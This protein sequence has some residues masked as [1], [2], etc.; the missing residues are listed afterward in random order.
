MNTLTEKEMTLLK[1]EK[2]NEETCVEK[3]NQYASQA[4]C[5]Q[6]KALFQELGSKEQEHLNTIN[7]IMSG[8]VPNV[9]ASQ[10][11]GQSSQ[12]QAMTQSQSTLQSQAISNAQPQATS[13]TNKKSDCYLCTDAL[14][15]E[16]HVS[17]TY[18]TAIFEFADTNIRQALNHIQ[19]EEQ[20]HG[21]QIYNYMDQNGMYN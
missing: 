20:E 14:S 9:N 6:L 4:S 16:K 3:Y 18:N 2:K 19:K 15:T 1:D 5:P 21:E 13:S 12:S 17:S 11:S 8:T 10:G 7:Q